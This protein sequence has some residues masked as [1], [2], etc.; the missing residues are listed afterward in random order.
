MK[1]I[2]CKPAYDEI[3]CITTTKDEITTIQQATDLL[4][5]LWHKLQNQPAIC[6]TIV[7]EIAHTMRYA[8]ADKN[9]SVDI[10]SHRLLNTIYDMVTFLIGLEEVLEYENYVVNNSI[11]IKEGE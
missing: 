1:T 3:S 10:K 11:I 5:D 4:R 7:D 6:N 8:I 9:D 2:T